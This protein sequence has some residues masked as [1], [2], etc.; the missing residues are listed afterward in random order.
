MNR[1]QW[2]TA[3]ILGIWLTI[4]VIGV[5]PIDLLFFVKCVGFVALLEVYRYLQRRSL[6]EQITLFALYCWVGVFILW[7][8]PVLSWTYWIKYLST[9]ILVIIYK[10]Q[11]L[12]KP[13]DQDNQVQL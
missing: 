2:I 7:Y 8:I 6:G 13:N 1:K 3:C 4:V 5:P 10:A 11:G 9:V 12:E